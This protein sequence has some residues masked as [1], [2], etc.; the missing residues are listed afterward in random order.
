LRWKLNRREGIDF[1]I[2][3]LGA[4][5]RKMTAAYRRMSPRFT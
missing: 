3:L 5:E 2:F 1:S 4:F